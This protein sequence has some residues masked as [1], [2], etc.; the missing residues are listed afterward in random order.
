MALKCHMQAN[1]NVMNH[2]QAS[3]TNEI[4]SPLGLELEL[5][6]H[7]PSAQAIPSSRQVDDGGWLNKFSSSGQQGLALVDYC[8][9]NPLAHSPSSRRAY[10][11]FQVRRGIW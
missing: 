7:R 2:T 1:L 8:I 5:E 6:L 10:F 3:L 4:T 9:N 11:A